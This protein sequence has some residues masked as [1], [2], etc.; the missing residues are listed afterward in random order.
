MSEVRADRLVQQMREREL[1]ALLV[2]N[3]MNVRYL[4]GFTGTNARS[5]GGSRSS[6]TSASARSRARAW[7]ATERRSRC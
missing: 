1:D 5:G 7:T 6:A 4:S 2:T 3:L